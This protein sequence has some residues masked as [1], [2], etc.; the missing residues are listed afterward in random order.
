M[1]DAAHSE[2][3][4]Q[5]RNYQQIHAC[6]INGLDA[7]NKT[8]GLTKYKK[9]KY[10][11]SKNEQAAQAQLQFAFAEHEYADK[12]QYDECCIIN[13]VERHRCGLSECIVLKNLNVGDGKNVHVAAPGGSAQRKRIKSSTGENEEQKIDGLDTLNHE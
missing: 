11:G 8:I 13:A 3:N 4:P 9:N 10:D 5:Q 12:S 6:M 7:G 1:A 2:K